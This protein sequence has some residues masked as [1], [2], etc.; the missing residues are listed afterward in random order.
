MHVTPGFDYIWVNSDGIN[1]N[2]MPWIQVQYIINSNLNLNMPKHE[3]FQ[4]EL[5]L[6]I[7]LEN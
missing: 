4:L 2:H 3:S 7:Q 6:S 5:F 1:T